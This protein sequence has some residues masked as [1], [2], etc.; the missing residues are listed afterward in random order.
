MALMIWP[1]AGV[2]L[3]AWSPSPNLPHADRF[4]SERPL[5]FIN[6]FYGVQPTLPYNFTITLKVFSTQS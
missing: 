1:V 3:V 6:Y 5:Y 2:E 4:Y